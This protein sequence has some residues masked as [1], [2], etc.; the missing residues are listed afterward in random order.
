[1]GRINS[2]NGGW[3]GL[4]KITTVSAGGIEEP[5]YLNA[6]MAFS[7]ASAPTGWTK[8]TTTDDAIVRIVSGTPT[9]GGTQ[10]VG[11]VFAPRNIYPSVGPFPIT[12]GPTTVSTAQMAAHNHTM[13]PGVVNFGTLTL[14]GRAAVSVT[15]GFPGVTAPQAAPTLASGQPSVAAGTGHTHT[16][17]ATV[18][19][20]SPFDFRVKY[21]DVILAKYTG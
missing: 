9:T 13:A 7:Q 4:N 14:P 19:I 10:P 5:E 20:N 17:S 12:I 21:V 6:I 2:L 16:G 1:M 11:T 18:N 3:I 8:E 15:R